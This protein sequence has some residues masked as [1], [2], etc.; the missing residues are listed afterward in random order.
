MP[1]WKNRIFAIMEFYV[2]LIEKISKRYGRLVYFWGYD[3]II[4]PYFKKVPPVTPKIS[5]CRVP[6]LKT[7]GYA[8]DLFWNN[9]RTL[10]K[11]FNGKISLGISQ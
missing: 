8:I 4:Q 2:F 7:L 1:Y 3:Y 10:R 6:R 5:K 11:Y 9:G